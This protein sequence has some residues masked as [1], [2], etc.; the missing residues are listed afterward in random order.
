MSLEIIAYF[1]SLE[2][3]ILAMLLAIHGSL[4]REKIHSAMYYALAVC[5]VF[6][7]IGSALRTSGSIHADGVLDFVVTPALAV[8]IIVTLL[9]IWRVRKTL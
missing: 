8:A 4:K 7:A 5:F 3:I 6:I 1:R 2:Y 9:N